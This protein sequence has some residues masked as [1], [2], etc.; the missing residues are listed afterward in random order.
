[1]PVP[2]LTAQYQ[3]QQNFL[4]FF[5]SPSNCLFFQQKPLLAAKWRFFCF[6]LLNIILFTFMLAF[7]AVQFS[8][9][10]LYINISLY[11]FSYFLQVDDAAQFF[12]SALYTVT[13]PFCQLLSC[14]IVSDNPYLLHLKN[15]SSYVPLYQMPYKT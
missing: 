8:L 11:I 10:K 13:S 7:K 1:M 9:Y 3:S 6:G 14:F 5:F 2:C 4:Y 15:V 12:L